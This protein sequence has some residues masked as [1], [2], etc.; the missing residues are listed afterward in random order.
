MINESTIGEP[1]ALT[2]RVGGSELWVPMGGSLKQGSPLWIP[3]IVRH[4]YKRGPKRDPNLENYTYC[5]V[6]CQN[7]ST[8][9]TLCT[10]GEARP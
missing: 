3:N 5:V 1:E 4:L 9:D 10:A 6:V 2:I 8:W 7:Q